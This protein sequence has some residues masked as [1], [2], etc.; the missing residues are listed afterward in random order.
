MPLAAGRQPS[1]G[2]RQSSYGPCHLTV[3]CRTVRSFS[4]KGKSANTRIDRDQISRRRKSFCPETVRN[5]DAARLSSSS[6]HRAVSPFQGE[7]LQQFL[8]ELG[9]GVAALHAFTGRGRMP[10][11]KRGISVQ[12]PQ[13]LARCRRLLC[14]KRGISAPSLHAFT[15]RGRIPCREN[16]IRIEPPQ[17]LARRRRL[18][19]RELRISVQPAHRSPAAAA[20]R[21]AN[22]GSACSRSRV[23]LDAAA[24]L[25]ASTGSARRRFMRSDRS[26][27]SSSDRR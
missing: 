3:K 11:G 20:W 15:G 1:L 12:P 21:A 6:H 16:G 27:R 22:S 23:A 2:R 25:A 7:R 19:C 8:P 10:H 4:C 13:G 17:R 26:L 9:I 18:L 5:P 14:R 24:F